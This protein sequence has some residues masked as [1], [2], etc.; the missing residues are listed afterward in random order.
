M[1]NTFILGSLNYGILTEGYNTDWLFK[2]QKTITQGN[3]QS[4]INAHTDSIFKNL[5]I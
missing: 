3:I 4:K 1:Y 5:P 2:L